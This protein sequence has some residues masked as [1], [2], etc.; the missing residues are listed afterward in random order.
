MENNTEDQSQK[1][2]T[3]DQENSEKLNSIWKDLKVIINGILDIRADTDKKGTIQD[4]KDS[5]SMKGHT[6]WVLSFSILIASIGM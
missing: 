1:K 4:V 5:I 3:F 6:A 2:E